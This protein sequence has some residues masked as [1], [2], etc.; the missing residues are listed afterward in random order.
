MIAV[1][2]SEGGVQAN[3]QGIA[4]ACTERRLQVAVEV[5][6]GRWWSWPIW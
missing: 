3:T 1:E 5:V 6:S 2:A 4:R